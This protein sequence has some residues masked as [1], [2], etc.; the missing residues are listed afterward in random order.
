MLAASGVGKLTLV[1]N[2][3]IELTNLT[4]QILF[5]EEDIG[6]PKTKVLKRTLIRR[7]SQKEMG[8]IQKC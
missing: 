8:G 5:T 6:L 2:D 1:D 7:N 3:V 4:R